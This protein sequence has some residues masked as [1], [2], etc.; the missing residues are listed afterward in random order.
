MSALHLLP[1][2][3]KSGY[4]NIWTDESRS[5]EIGLEISNVATATIQVIGTVQVD[6]CTHCQ[7]NDDPFA[8]CVKAAESSACGNCHWKEKM[9]DCPFYDAS[10]PTLPPP[11]SGCCCQ[12]AP[13]TAVRADVEETQKENRDKVRQELKGIYQERT[14]LK[15]KMNQLRL[16]IREARLASATFAEMNSQNCD[17]LSVQKGVHL[18]DDYNVFLRDEF[19]RAQRALIDQIM[20]D[21]EKIMTR[22]LHL[23]DRMAL[24]KSTRSR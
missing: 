9:K 22:D 24:L 15:R 13:S 19:V 16:I 8:L 7:Q 21:F 10:A 17:T 6:E 3:Q 11:H 4:Q 18:T 1:P 23:L 2:G 12:L 5:R 14:A 20:T